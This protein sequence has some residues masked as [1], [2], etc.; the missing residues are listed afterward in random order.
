MTGSTHLAC[1]D[2]SVSPDRGQ[3]ARAA[4]IAA[5][6]SAV[7][8]A[9]PGTLIQRHVRCGKPRCACHADPPVL[10]GPYWQWTRK[11]AGK[12]IT[13]LVPDE[14]LDDYRQWIDNDRRLR[15]LVAE[16]EALTLA[17]ADASPRSRHRSQRNP[18]HQRP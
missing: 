18:P 9:L 3:R 6:L 5:E 7:G 2:G 4:A 13:R 16:L 10:H 17:I 14:Q 8:L 11:A 1:D 12:T 15:E